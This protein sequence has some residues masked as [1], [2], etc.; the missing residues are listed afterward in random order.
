[1]STS[2][3]EI[4]RLIAELDGIGV[5]LWTE[6][7]QLRFRAPKG[8]MTPERVA[9]LRARKAAILNHLA[10]IEAEPTV[11]PAPE[12]RHDPFPLTDIQSA[13]LLGRNDG[14][15]YGGVACHGYLELGV[16]TVDTERLDAAWWALIQRHDMLRAVIHPDGYQQVLP[17]VE[18]RPLRVTD[19]R[20]Q[21]AD[22]SLAE[23]RA[24]LAHRVYPADA[25][26]LY[27]LAVTRTDDGDLL[28]LSI[29]LLIADYQSVQL[30]LRELDTLY[31]DPAHE[32]P[33]LELTFRDYVR[34]HRARTQPGAQGGYERDR[35]Y[36]LGRVDE[37]PPAPELP[38]ADRVLD[39]GTHRENTG[40]ARFTRH[41][42]TLDPARWERLRQR[43]AEAG[44]TASAAVLAAY[45]EVIGAWSRTPRFTLNLTVLN[46]EPLHPGVDRLVGDFTS[47]NL[48]AVDQSPNDSTADFT[49]RARDVHGQLLTD[50][51][52]RAFSG[53]EVLRELARRRG[54]TEALMPVVYTSTIGAAEA[55]APD[56]LLAGQPI[57]GLS[58]TPQ[59][60]IDCQ[61]ME[62]QGALLVNWDVRDGVFPSGMIA[63]AFAA[64]EGL[65]LSL[66]EG[67]SWTAAHPVAL[68]AVELRDTTAPLP[69]GLL[70]DAVVA[71]AEAAPT[72]PAVVTEDRTVS[73]RELIDSANAVAAALREREVAAGELVAV[74][75]PKSPEQIAAVLGVLLAGGAYLPI[76]PD[77]PPV[78]RDTILADAAVRTVITTGGTWPETVVPL[79]IGAL[80]ASAPVEPMAVAPDGPAYAIYTSGS[81]GTPKGVLISHRAALNTVRDINSRYGVN[82]SDRVLGLAELGFDLS[83]YDIFGLLA[84]GGCV[85]L[86]DPERTADPSHWADLIAENGVSIWNSVPTQLQMLQ[87]FLATS[88]GVELFTLRLGLL[89]GDWIPV[90]LPTA[91][92]AQ[93]PLMQMVGLGGAT[94]AS[95]WSIHHDIGEI[96]EAWHSIPYG[97]PLTNQT[98]HVLDDA[99][100]TR[101]DWV[102]G[103]LYIGGAG[104]AIGYLGDEERTA[105]RFPTH[106]STGERLYRTGDYGRRLPNGEIEFLGRI[107]DQ[108]KIRGH[109]IELAEVESALAAHPAVASAVALVDGD[110]PMRRRIVAFARAAGRPAG[111]ADGDGVASAVRA[112]AATTAARGLDVPADDLVT[113]VR[114]ADEVA[115]LAMAAT[116]RGAGL[117]ADQA[118][119]FDDIASATGAATRHHRLLRRW[120]NALTTAGMLRTD[121]D[122]YRD[123]GDSAPLREK[124]AELEDTVQRQAYG[125]ELVQY[126]RGCAE[127]LP[128][129][130]RDEQ[131]PLELLFPGQNLDT[132]QAAFR[133]N[134]V[135]QHLNRVLAESVRAIAAE[136]GSL[137][138]L[139][140][141]AGVAGTS[142][143]LIPAL[144]GYDVDYLFTDV[145]QFFLSEARQTFAEYPWVS[146]GIYDLNADPLVQGYLP[147]SFDVIVSGNALHLAKN[148]P[149]ALERLRSL[150]APGGWLAFIEGTGENLPLM[151]SME[152]QGELSGFTD[153]R[154]TTDQTLLTDE[155]WRH[156]L[157]DAGASIEVGVDATDAEVSLGRQHVFLARFKLDRQ[158]VTVAEI[159][160]HAASRLP[161]YMLPAHLQLVDEF[162][163]SANGKLDRPRLRA[164]L[165]KRGEERSRPAVAPTDELERRLVAI[166]SDVLG[167]PNLGRDDDFFAVGGDSLLLARL[168]GQLLEREPTAEGIDF[169]LLLGQVLRRPTVAALAAYL[170]T[171]PGASEAVEQS[172]LVTL[173]EGSGPAMVL[174]HEGTGTLAPYRHLIGA[175][176][177]RPVRLLGIE[178]RR[179]EHYLG[180]DTDELIKRLAED[181][182][183]RLLDAG[184]DTVHLVGYCLGGFLATE[185]ARVL[186]EAGAQVAS[187][188]AVSSY[189][190]PYEVED[191]LAAD[192]AFARIL[193]ADLAAVGFPT[194]EAEFRSAM[195]AV[196]AKTPGRVPDGALGELDGEFA[197]LAAAFRKLAKQPHDERL[198]AI[199]AS[200]P[201]GRFPVDGEYLRTSY[202]MFRHN[203]SALAR[204]APEPYVGPVTL[205]RDSGHARLLPTRDDESTTFWQR[206]C[207]DEP[208]I[209]DIQGDHFSCLAPPHVDTVG[210]ILT[211]EPK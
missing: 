168:I 197:E 160:A 69:D 144:A 162:P 73:Y 88:P 184:V 201:A 131:S 47:V 28:H 98:W 148:A 200:L 112:A 176:S 182:A 195:R 2:S 18:R 128:E 25:W 141:G 163:L 40:K 115:L 6:D 114:A 191:D 84:V 39:D 150:L 185:I 72:R 16:S 117:F 172:P 63:E 70:H 123:L 14:F 119:S 44:V 188:T 171:V 95:I 190:V 32:L 77:A 203:L 164:L 5:R 177:E 83:V 107:D 178:A 109:R 202:R 105:Q 11:R 113:F 74:A 157:E 146:Y 57:G 206:L 207:V 125:W 24:D 52:H 120:L 10:A 151:V 93:V 139:E 110:K 92:R 75:L 3:P 189:R 54:R 116:L 138:V 106:P 183:R 55:A 161:E 155:Q 87:D 17:E 159:T 101:P 167:H 173:A 135:N 192:Y 165:P 196:L 41:Q 180:I 175:L 124:L 154:H 68:P 12:E 89:S 61:A 9:E 20:G 127:H 36:W 82:R 205:L 4:P 179:P 60:W 48:L 133:D 65:L 102:A 181:Y 186:T 1:M 33:A 153:L 158:P 22:S 210:T 134:P 78:R 118:H 96:P 79:D 194:D 94:E 30:L 58:Q 142:S 26:P 121:G 71:A 187:L 23:I 174:V 211:Q 126:L 193:G 204:Y 64:F 34:A 129:L 91:I 130:L 42:V 100:R 169:G 51:D 137:R 208:S 152:F 122:Q 90:A 37:L 170:R 27:E 7:G 62:W 49:A 38:L 103:E 46:R 97:A 145:T 66:S 19:L 86:P 35:E 85:V 199:V 80:P 166:W 140:I 8:V 136:R 209:V 53:V 59:V 43:A 45:A 108:V 104:L 99:L 76:D 143:A 15:D 50:L 156:L 81:T 198:E 67:E 132:A 21:D 13:Y 149:E 31:R 56:G 147:N 111:D 29:D